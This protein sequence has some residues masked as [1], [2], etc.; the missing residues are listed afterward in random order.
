[1]VHNKIFSD[2][3]LKSLMTAKKTSHSPTKNCTLVSECE[4]INQSEDLTFDVLKHLYVNG[5]EFSFNKIFTVVHRTTTILK[6]N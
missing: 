5:W 1:M 4:C 3:K 6:S 2:S